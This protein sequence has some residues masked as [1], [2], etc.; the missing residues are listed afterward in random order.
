MFRIISKHLKMLQSSL[1]CLELFFRT[2]WLSGILGFRL[3]VILPFDDPM[4]MLYL[5]DIQS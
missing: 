5:S 1:Y 3:V 2:S 4:F